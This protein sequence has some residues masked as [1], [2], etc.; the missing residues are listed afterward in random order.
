MPPNSEAPTLD[1]E[2][3]AYAISDLNEQA[4]RF[5]GEYREGYVH[6][7][8]DIRRRVLAGE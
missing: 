7:L 4:T 6:A 1:A 2:M 8:D 5:E 3:V